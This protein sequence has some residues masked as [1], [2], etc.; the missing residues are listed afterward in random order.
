MMLVL[1]F[2]ALAVPIVT[3]SLNLS[4][5]LNVDSKNK[6]RDLKSEY[7]VLAGSHYA[8]HRLVHEP[9]FIASLPAG[10]PTLYP[11]I[12][13]ERTSTVTVLKR[14]AVSDPP[15]GGGLS[16]LRATKTVVPTSTSPNTTTTFTYTI[17]VQNQG[18][19]PET[20]TKVLDGLPSGFAYVSGSTTGLTT[21]NPTI[22]VRQSGLGGTSYN[23]LTWDV[24]ALGLV[25]QPSSQ[26]TLT[27]Q[28]Q[29]SVATGN[30]CNTAW[31]EPGGLQT[32]SGYT[33]KIK[34]GSP[35]TPYCQG[36]IAIINKTVTPTVAPSHTTTTFSY[37]ITIQ[38]V[39]T[40]TIGAFW[41]VDILPP[42]FT[43]LSGST[44]G[45]LTT[46]NP[47]TWSSDG[48]Q[49]LNWLFLPKRLINPGQTKTLNFQARA[50]PSQ[51]FFQNEVWVYFD[52]FAAYSYSWPTAGI[53][54]EDYIEVTVDDGETVVSSKAWFDGTEY[55]LDHWSITR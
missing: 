51:G 10:V 34:V 37:S 35:S 22:T 8:L 49:Y 24:S 9:G 11:L 39:S 6:T 48:R 32:G 33:A 20:L 25:I 43:Y 18:I 5:T 38:N 28:A 52:A 2:M 16:P 23:Q 55:T 12:F 27:F 42:G 15:P 3:M 29:A 40:S 13:N 36:E 44:S 30:Y 4:S 53:T 41:I 1:A 46:A 45:D 50:T 17:T 26:V 21:Q 47:F 19:E 31:V 7:S 54:V 14:S